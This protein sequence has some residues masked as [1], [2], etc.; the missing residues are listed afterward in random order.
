MK[1]LLP[2]ALTLSHALAAEQCYDMSIHVCGCTASVCNEEK[3]GA[4]GGVWSD[5]C[6][7][8]KCVCEDDTAGG[9]I[10]IDD[11]GVSHTIPTNATIVLGAMDA[12]ALFHFGLGPDRIVATL[13]ERSSSGS[14]HGG[15]YYDGNVV[16]DEL[17]HGS[18]EYDPS[19]FPADPNVEERAFLDSIPGDLSPGCSSTNFYCDTVN[20][21]DLVD[22]GW[23]DVIIIGGF[24]EGFAEKMRNASIAENIPLIVLSSSYS[25]DE[26]ETE[27]IRN[28]V[29][30]TERMESLAV[31]LGLDV[32]SNSV[33]EDDKVALCAA[34]K[35]FQATAKSAHEVGV[36][37]M[38]SYMPYQVNDA[39]YTSAFIPNP[40]R[41]PVLSM[42]QNLGLPIL[43]NE[44][45]GTYWENRV[46]DYSAGSG[47]FTAEDTMSVSGNF[48]Y[49]VDFWL[50]DDRVSLDFLSEKFAQDWPHPAITAKQYAYW[51]SNFRI[52]SYRHATEILTIVGAS[53]ATAMPVTPASTCVEPTGDTQIRDLGPGEFSCIKI[54]PIDFCDTAA[55]D[56]TETTSADAAATTSKDDAASTAIVD[57]DTTTSAD[58]TAASTS[59]DAD[60]S[61]S[62][63]TTT[64][65]TS[66]DADTSASADTTAASTSADDAAST[67]ADDANSS[68]ADVSAM[69]SAGIS[70][71]SVG[72]FAVIIAT[73]MNMM[74]LLF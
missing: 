25:D 58:T 14:N 55:S 50:Y 59:A 15:Y 54:F 30:M 24:Y 49:N 11:N 3:C 1:L 57:A 61:A 22:N 35:S 21:T 46:G 23:P 10:F 39:G 29:E 31:S 7:G 34:A 63:D 43:Y 28:M 65:S 12:V 17:D 33:V 48:S 52:I 45:T 42:M 4:T 9:S 27:N 69:S 38:A 18:S 60:T 62:A 26:G 2:L 41:D 5:Q 71:K 53:L 8:E 37:T 56:T 73:T 51:P 74:Y 64:A 72:A 19:I 70:V 47:D 40:D 6:P 36:R 13:G 32:G 66:A 68:T 44:H 20:F 16:Y 67:S